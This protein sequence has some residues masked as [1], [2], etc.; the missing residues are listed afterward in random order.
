MM[1]PHLAM[2]S[3]KRS[4]DHNDFFFS[5][6]TH[7]CIS[8][9]FHPNLLI[10]GVG[11]GRVQSPCEDSVPTGS[12]QRGTHPTRSASTKWVPRSVFI[13]ERQRLSSECVAEKEPHAP[14]WSD[15]ARTMFDR[16]CIGEL[17]G[18]VSV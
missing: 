5:I 6:G 4:T 16:E 9:G 10:G 8:G 11:Q 17:H 3:L 2:P 18:T 15:A 1:A 14:P 12:S 13:L 7:H